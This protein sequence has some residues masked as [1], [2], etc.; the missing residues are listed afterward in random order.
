MATSTGPFGKQKCWDSFGNRVP[1]PPGSFP[2]TNPGNVPAPGFTI[3]PTNPPIG[4]PAGIQPGAMQP[5][6]TVIGPPFLAP[7]PSMP[8][9]P[10]GGPAPAAA[11]P[12]TSTLSGLFS[13]PWV[14]VA[15]VVG[16]V[17]LLGKK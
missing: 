7:G 14:L 16:A 4:I 10:A 12:A 2:Q 1:C 9:A 17:L 8:A 3:N 6:G 5:G 11:A 15:V 13:N